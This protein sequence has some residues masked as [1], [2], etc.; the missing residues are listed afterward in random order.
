[1]E[2]RE[3]WSKDS[4]KLHHELEQWKTQFEAR[5]TELHDAKERVALAVVD[6]ERRLSISIDLWGLRRHT[7]PKVQS[8]VSDDFK[9]FEPIDDRVGCNGA[10][11]FNSHSS[12]TSTLTLSSLRAYTSLQAALL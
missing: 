1:M 11:Q 2:S 9:R 8:M 12:S 7:N 10:R 3:H 4:E 5:S 6:I